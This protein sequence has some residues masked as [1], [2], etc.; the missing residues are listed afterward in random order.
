VYDIASMIRRL[1]NNELA[2]T[3]RITKIS[4]TA[5]G[6][7]AELSTRDFSNRIY[8]SLAT[9]AINYTKTRDF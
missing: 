4:A 6:L 2:K 7:A 3:R 5:V 1:L 9:L 8:E